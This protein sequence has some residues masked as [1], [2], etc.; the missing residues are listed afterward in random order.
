MDEKLGGLFSG[1]YLAG[2][3]VGRLLKG[4]GTVIT[5]YDL[6]A[7]AMI[8]IGIGMI[9]LAA[10]LAGTGVGLFVGT[11]RS[12]TFGLVVLVIVSV[13]NVETIVLSGGQVSLLFTPETAQL[14]ASAQLGA[15]LL[16]LAY[17]FLV[18]PTTRES[19]TVDSAESATR[20]GTTLR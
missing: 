9:A 20:V 19:R 15:N 2:L 17:L 6:G 4:I 3:A 11:D 1:V 7:E 18:D 13:I 14:L 10:V 8:G 12:R 5:A 16:V